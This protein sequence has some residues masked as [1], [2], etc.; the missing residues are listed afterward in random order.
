MSKRVNITVSD[1]IVDFFQLQADEMGIPRSAVMVMALKTYM[2]QQK[3]LKV[4]DIYKSME[5]L[6]EQLDQLKEEKEN[7]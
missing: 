4:A 5:H 1:E 3:S 2:D 6:I 7:Q